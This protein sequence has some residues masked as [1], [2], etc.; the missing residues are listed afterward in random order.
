MISK[1]SVLSWSSGTAWVIAHGSL[2]DSVTVESSDCPVAESH[3]EITTWK[4]PLVLKPRGP[5]SGPC[6]IKIRFQQKYEISQIYVRST[7]RAYE[8]YYAHSSHSR[9]EYI[10]TVWC[11]AAERDE[12]LLQINCTEDVV[13]EHGESLARELT[14]ENVIREESVGHTEDDWVKNKVP[15]VARSS[16]SDKIST[17]QVKNVQHLYEAAAQISDADPC[18]LLTI[19][20]LSLQDKG[21]V[22]VDDVYVFGDPVESTDSGKEAVLTGCSAQSLKSENRIQDEHPSGKVLKGDYMETGSTRIGEKMENGSSTIDEKTENG[23]TR[24]CEKIETGSGRIDE[25]DFGLEINQTHQQHVKPKELDKGTTESAELEQPTL[26][27][28]FVEPL[29]IN[30]MPPGHLGRALE[31]L[32]SRRLEDICLRFEE[33]MLK[34]I[35]NIAARLQQVVHQLEKLAMNSQFSGLP[36]GARFCASA[37]SCSESN[38]SSFYNDPNDHS[39]CGP[40]ELGK[41]DF[42]CNNSPELSCDAKSHASFFVRAPDFLCGE[43]E[44]TDDDD[45]ILLKHFTCI[46]LPELSHVAN[47]H[48]SLVSSAPEFW[49]N[50]ESNNDSKPSKDSPHVEP[51]KTSSVDDA[52]AAARIHPSEQIQTTSSVSSEVDYENQDEEHAESHQ[53]IAQKLP[54]AEDCIRESSQYSQ[55]FTADAPDLT[56]EEETGNTEHLSYTKSSLDKTSVVENEDTDHDNDMVP[57]SYQNKSISTSTGSCDLVENRIALDFASSCNGGVTAGS[58]EESR[59]ASPKSKLQKVEHLLEAGI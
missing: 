19:R 32:I 45:S 59:T 28:K 6:E 54:A 58:V 31:Q 3:P 33:K 52:L 15:E 24:I 18:S 20:L 10:C 40:S 17:N 44:E 9:N 23:S 30:D 29:N 46:N 8:V 34:P 43:D 22:Y 37:F 48:P 50:E 56:A 27:K 4:S 26:E 53:I 11:G 47:V 1:D 42:S 25:I 13:V 14:D 49:E 51:K 55:V 5:D 41:K 7:A 57:P 16:V 2:E 39:P 36:P 38:S 21:Q 12:K 35:E